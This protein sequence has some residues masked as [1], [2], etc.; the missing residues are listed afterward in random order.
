MEKTNK[1]IKRIAFFGDADLKPEDPTCKSAYSTAKLLAESG[2][3]I[4]NGG[5]PGI[6][7]AATSGA[8]A[9]NGVVELVVMDPKF[10]PDNYEGI[11]DA[12][13][14]LSSKTYYQ[15]SYPERLNKLIEIADAFVVFKGGTGTLSEVGLIWENAKFKYGNHEPIIFFGTE[16]REVINLL[17]KKMNYES[18]EKSVVTV[19]DTPEEVLKI[20]N[21]I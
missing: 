11:D 7:G 20:L 17:E 9:G 6:M 13:L 10:A 18:I 12:N 1:I 14:K 2:Y 16:W 21:K 8:K 5:G 3:I 19:V 15:K 4:V